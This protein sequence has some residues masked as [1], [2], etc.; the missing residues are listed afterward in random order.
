[1]AARDGG[2]VLVTGFKS[3]QGFVRT[4]EL[5]EFACSLRASKPRKRELVFPRDTS[6]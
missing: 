6:T 4:F 5:A 1:M 3:T 2:V